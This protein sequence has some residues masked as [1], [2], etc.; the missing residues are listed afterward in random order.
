MRAIRAVLTILLPT[1][2]LAGLTATPTYAADKKEYD[3]LGVAAAP[4]SS[5]AGSSG[6]PT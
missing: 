3:C 5:T 4:D 6:T 2:A 1:V